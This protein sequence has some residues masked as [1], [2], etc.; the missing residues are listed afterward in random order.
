L[1]SPISYKRCYAAFYVW[2][3]PCIRIGDSLLQ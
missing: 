1:F 3:I 2:K